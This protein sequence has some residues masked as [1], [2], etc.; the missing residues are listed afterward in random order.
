MNVIWVELLWDKWLYITQTLRNLAGSQ[1]K[2]GL[3][4]LALINQGFVL[5]LYKHYKNPD[6]KLA[7]VVIVP[8]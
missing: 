8:V 1:I 7:C 2:Y 6:W 4:W 5:T 3:S